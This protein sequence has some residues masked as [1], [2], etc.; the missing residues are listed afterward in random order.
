MFGIGHKYGKYADLPMKEGGTSK[1]SALVSRPI[2]TRLLQE[3]LSDFAT[4]GLIVLLQVLIV[5]GQLLWAGRQ[6]SA[7]SKLSS[8]NYK[9]SF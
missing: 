2:G 1:L 6:K 8:H 7:C 5:R 9:F 3:S 4:S